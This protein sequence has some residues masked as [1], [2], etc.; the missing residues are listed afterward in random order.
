M[1]LSEKKIWLIAFV[2]KIQFQRSHR[3]YNT[4]YLNQKQEHTGM[5]KEYA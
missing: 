1:E 2:Y 5:G 3:D 4:D